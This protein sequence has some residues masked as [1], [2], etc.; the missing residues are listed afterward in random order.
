MVLYRKGV[1]LIDSSYQLRGARKCAIPGC[2]NTS[3][4]GIFVG[5]FCAPCHNYITGKSCGSATNPSQAYR[6]ELTKANFRVLAGMKPRDGV[7]N[8]LVRFEQKVLNRRFF[9]DSLYGK[10]GK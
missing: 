7:E 9:V 1:N 4:Q 2:P 10:F 3:C 5:K 6:N 8:A